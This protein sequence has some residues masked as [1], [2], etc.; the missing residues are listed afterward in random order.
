MNKLKKCF[1]VFS[2]VALLMLST[3]AVS[4]K[5]YKSP[6]AT[7]A[8]QHSSTGSVVIYFDNST[9]KWS[10]VYAYIYVDG[11]ENAPWPG[12]KMTYDPTTGYYKLVVPANLKYGK[13]IFSDGGSN[14]YPAEGGL[15][16][17]GRDMLF[18]AGGEWVPYPP[19]TPSSTSPVTG[20]MTL[21]VIIAL[22]GFG[23]V[24]ALASR[25]LFAK[26]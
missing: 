2:V 7:T 22:V 12:I 6:T 1:A 21:Y 16:I 5:T 14:R 13:V 26:K 17:G 25:K 19:T 23:G 8:R 4:A 10:E 24:S 15:P 20:D 3:V 9:L 18:T 11:G